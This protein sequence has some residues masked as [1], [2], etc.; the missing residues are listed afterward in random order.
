M[1]K[2]IVWWLVSIQ[3]FPS[4]ETLTQYL[5]K[6]ATAEHCALSLADSSVD[7]ATK[8]ECHSITEFQSE[9]RT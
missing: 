5:H 4:G 3:T 2:V 7:K 1:I 8:L 9:G 6:F